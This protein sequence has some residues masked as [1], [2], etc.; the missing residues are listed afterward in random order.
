[1]TQQEQASTPLTLIL[2]TSGMAGPRRDAAPGML[3]GA[4]ELPV[5]LFRRVA[6]A[7]SGARANFYVMLPSDVGIGAAPRATLGSDRGSDNPL[8]GVEHLTGA[9]G[10]IR[11]PLDATG[12]QSLIRVARESSAYY[13]AELEPLANE[14]YGRNSRLN[15]RV[16]RRGVTV[17][18]RPE[19]RFDQAV[20]SRKTRLAVPDLLSSD[21]A[22]PDV[23]LRVGGFTVRDPENRLRLGIVIEPA[24]RDVVLES[25]GA[26]LIA[27]DGRVAGHWNARSVADRPLLGAI[28]ADAGT[29]RLRAAAVDSSGRAGAAEQLVDVGLTPIGPL[30]LGSLMLGVSRAGSTAP[31]LE[32]QAE[33][34]AIA[35]FDIYGGAEG[36]PLAVRLEVARDVDGPAV[37]AQPMVLTRADERR[38]VASGTVP[39][40]ALPPGDYI[41]RGI[42]RLESGET[43]RVIRT[44]RKIPR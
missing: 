4:G 1:L 35:Y 11:F 26:I 40:G 13:V 36:L 7:A 15:V 22:Y 27:P 31:Q 16:T 6:A 34:T 39:I 25:A 3:P 42:L 23:R 2:F 24:S 44:L 38:V 37:I 33:P 12:E 10:G 5:E 28:A 32:F 9:T 19:I 41:A 29:Y 30:T 43:A 8:D 17:G 14:V 21:D 20:A 18:A